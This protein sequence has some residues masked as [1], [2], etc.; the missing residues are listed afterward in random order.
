MLSNFA[1]PSIIWCVRAYLALRSVVWCT[2]GC[3]VSF[4]QMQ[5]FI[6]G[7]SPN[8]N[9]HTE[10][11][12]IFRPI[13]RLPPPQISPGHRSV[14]RHHRRIF[15]HI[16]RLPQPLISPGHRSVARHHRRIFR[17]IRR[18][19]P[20]PISPGHRLVA[21][22]HRR[23]FLPIRRLPPPLISPSHRSVA[24]I[25]RISQPIRRWQQRLLDHKGPQ[26]EQ[27]RNST[28]HCRR[29]PLV[30]ELA[31]VSNVRES[32]SA[33]LRAAAELE[34]GGGRLLLQAMCILRGRP[35]PLQPARIWTA[36]RPR[37]EA[38][39]VAGISGFCT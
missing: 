11:R 23:I 34:S 36:F 28:C 14:A 22:H 20:P 16:R 13:R 1:P 26:C 39:G 10:H 4:S 18:L 24:R 19:P 38:Q 21:R 31:S 12:G 6:N 35:L 29:P 27:P 32:V 9:E 30:H 7:K 5:Q 3:V 15:L 17:P 33:M 2:E 25:R 37:R 8:L